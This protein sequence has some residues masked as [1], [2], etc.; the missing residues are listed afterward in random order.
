MPKYICKFANS[1]TTSNG[2]LVNFIENDIAVPFLNLSNTQFTIPLNEI[3]IQVCLSGN[4]ARFA[5]I[6]GPADIFVVNGSKPSISSSTI[7]LNVS[8]SNLLAHSA[9]GTNFT[10]TGTQPGNDTWRTF[11]NANLQG[12]SLYLYVTNG[13]PFW[14]TNLMA[15]VTTITMPSLRAGL[16]ITKEQMDTLK[17]YQ[18][19][20]SGGTIVPTSA[21]QGEC[22]TAE[23]ANSYQKGTVNV[24][25]SIQASWY[26]V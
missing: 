21:I 20:S 4:I 11:F 15:Q 24:N 3:P 18:L 25:D 13:P 9:G 16:I 8:G 7:I 23:L 22:A 26:A 2:T 19:Y 6:H 17:E 10:Y 14:V 1:Y 5:S 12:K